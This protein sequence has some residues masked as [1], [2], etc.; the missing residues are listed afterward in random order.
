[1]VF[2]SLDATSGAGAGIDPGQMRRGTCWRSPGGSIIDKRQNQQ[3]G[4]G[5]VRAWIVGALFVLV[6]PVVLAQSAEALLESKGC[7][8]CHGVDEK[9]MGP[10][11]RGAAAKYKGAEA[12][13]IWTPP[14][15]N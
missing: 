5:D 1:M 13:L 8:G 7:L 10:A 11:L 12:K 9:K 4:R 3:A 14:R 2:M 15:P 6:A